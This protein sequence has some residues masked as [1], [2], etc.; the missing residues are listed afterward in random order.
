MPNK[1][2][3]ATMF[4]LAAPT[5]A[6]AAPG[7]MSVATFIAKGEALQKKGMLAMMSSDMKL[8]QA[9][10]QGASAYY[11]ARLAADQQAGRPRHSCPPPK[12]QAKMDSAEIMAHMK[13]Y[14]VDRR[15]LMPVKQAFADLMAKKY[16]CR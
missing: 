16:P 3:L 4:L 1:V 2:T 11:R 10:M 14:P 9:E 5:L 15:A 6:L 7:D 8:L 13:S 12:G